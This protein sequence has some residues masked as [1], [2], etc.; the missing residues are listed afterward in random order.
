MISFRSAITIKLLNYFFMNP[1]EK[2]YVNEIARKLQLDKR[3]LMKKI[4]ELEGEGLFKHETRGNL[5]LYSINTKYPLYNE[6]R[7]IILKTYGLEDRLRKA[8]KGVKGVKK[9]YIYGSYAKNKMAP[10]SDVDIL[11]VGPHNILE[12][13]KVLNK[14]Q[15]EIEREIN[16]VNIDE[17]EFNEKL[18]K[19]DP[20]YSGVV[21]GNNIRII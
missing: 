9:A 10:S 4:K 1:H 12:L 21:K 2:L 3:N 13:Q 16:V 18:R 5:K 20:F 7:R 14:I 11:V 17:K 6:L 8:L 15:R 19:K